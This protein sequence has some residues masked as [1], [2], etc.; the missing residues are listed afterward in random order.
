M[1]R[2]HAA[3]ASLAI[4]AAGTAFAENAAPA[5][6][7]AETMAPAPVAGTTEAATTLAPTQ[8]VMPHTAT[9]SGLNHSVLGTWMIGKTIWTTEQPKGSGWDGYADLTERPADWDQ[10]GGVEDIVIAASGEVEGYVADIGGF[11]GIGA[12]RVLLSPD[13]LHVMTL[14]GDTFLATHYTADELRGLPAF[15]E[16]TVMTN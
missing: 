6:S 4:L 14:N 2:I 15:D 7:S 1:K 10:I 12:K 13:Q 16:E 5:A 3:A 11:L 8:E 9:V